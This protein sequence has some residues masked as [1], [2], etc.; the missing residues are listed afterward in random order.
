MAYTFKHGDRPLDGVTIQRAVGRGGFGEVYY[1]RTDSGKEIALKYLRDNPEIELRG[2]AQV[3]NLKSPH[4]ITIYDVRRNAAQDPFVLMEYVSGPSLHELLAAEPH[5]LGPQKAAFFLSG[6]AKGLTYLHDRGVVHRDLKPGNIFYDEGYVKIGDYGLSKHMSVSRHSGQTVSV[7]TVHYMAPEIGSGSYSKAIDIY[8]LGVI[9]FEM[10]TGKL[11]FTGSSMAEVLMRHLQDRPDL[12]G[13]PEPFAGVIAKA[14]QKNPADRYQ[15]VNEMVDAVMASAEINASCTSFDP[16]SLSNVERQAASEDF[17]RTV[18]TPP[19]LPP[20][21]SLDARA[22][23]AQQPNAAADEGIPV[24][25][26]IPPLPGERRGARFAQWRGRGPAVG[27]N[28]RVFGGAAAPLQGA[29][30]KRWPTVISLGVLVLA[31]AALL[32]LLTP[33]GN[34]ETVAALALYLAGGVIGPLLAHVR[35]LPHMH[36]RS[37]FVD[38]LLTAA[39]GFVFML[40]GLAAGSG[41]GHVERLIIP[42]TLCLLVCDWGRR[43]AQGRAGVVNGGSAVWPAIVG[44]I[45]TSFGKASGEFA[46]VGA[47]LCAAMAIATQLAASLW[48]API[49]PLS[50]RPPQPP[51][52]PADPGIRDRKWLASMV[53]NAAEKVER[54]Y[55]SATEAISA[56]IDVLSAPP[57]AGSTAVGRPIGFGWKLLWRILFALVISGSVALFI[58]C[59]FANDADEQ[60]GALFGGLAGVMLTP[61]LGIKAMQDRVQPLWAGTFRWLAMSLSL[62]LTAGMIAVL[63]FEAQDGAEI[64]GA[65]F[66]L[67][68]GVILAIVFACIPG[69]RPQPA[70]QLPEQA[71]AS[72]AGLEQLAAVRERVTAPSFVGRAANAGLSFVGKLLLLAG[73]SAAVLYSIRGVQIVTSGE[74]VSIGYGQITAHARGRTIQQP[75]PPQAV[76]VP[77][78]LGAIA[79]V[80]ARRNDGGAHFTRAIAS[81]GLVGLALAAALGPGGH[82]FAEFLNDADARAAGKIPPGHKRGDWPGAAVLAEAAR[83]KH[84]R[85]LIA[86]VRLSTAD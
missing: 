6:I 84:D 17:D 63:A 16:R 80:I 68:V 77:F 86:Q 73:L 45:A 39:L 11:P 60:A 33:S 56:K 10:L 5:G 21:P 29:L 7:G 70:V 42:M 62:T 47:G 53:E 34:E 25:P 71:A 15:D 37:G 27:V 13:I 66:G 52:P 76:L 36:V 51:Q 48:P 19:R 67:N 38:R 43:V 26:E 2:V 59:G 50:A 54:R 30:R 8:A 12:A 44:L 1:A 69:R 49:A 20:L 83:S 31:G 23:R 46:L 58:A 40:P 24:L 85:H 81:V 55:Q 3:M 74:A 35:I 72:E 9:L 14:L 61:F 22:V 32:A 65:V 4:L 28:V 82:E 41:S 64:A 18:T 78:A 79:I 75:I 57:S